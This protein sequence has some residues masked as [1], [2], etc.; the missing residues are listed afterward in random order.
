MSVAL[1]MTSIF[2]LPVE[3]NKLVSPLLRL[4]WAYFGFALTKIWT[5]SIQLEFQDKGCA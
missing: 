5:Y 3:S 1:E 4:N 2:S